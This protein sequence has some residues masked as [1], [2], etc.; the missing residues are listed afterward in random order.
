MFLLNQI[1]NGNGNWESTPAP[2]PHLLRFN[3]LEQSSAAN[4]VALDLHFAGDLTALLEE[5]LR[6][7]LEQRVR[8]LQHEAAEQAG[9]PEVKYGPRWL[10]A[11]GFYR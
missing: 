11:E 7:F 6:L 8:P 9:K 10:K 4:S 5:A 2:A 3:A 1:E